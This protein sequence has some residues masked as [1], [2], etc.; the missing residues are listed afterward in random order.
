MRQPNGPSDYLKL[1]ETYKMII[2]RNIPVMDLLTKNEARRFITFI[3]A[4]YENKV[5]LIISAFA[6]PENLFI[7]QD[8]SPDTANIM[9]K[10]SLGDLLGEMFKGKQ[11][12]NEIMK[13]AIFTAEDERFAF[14]RA[15]SRL[16]EMSSSVWWN[17]DHKPQLVDSIIKKTKFVPEMDSEETLK[18]TKKGEK[19][20]QV[21]AKDAE[22]QNKPSEEQ[23]YTDG[24]DFGE[25]AAFKGY[26]K[27][28]K[29]Y[30]TLKYEPDFEK[31]QKIEEQLKLRDSS[32]EGIRE[33]QERRE[34]MA[35]KFGEFHIWGMAEW[36]ERAGRWGQGVKAYITN[37]FKRL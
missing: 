6:D 34:S 7:T 5:K 36:G 32:P 30:D 12:S 35:P 1:C 22:P 25:E 9:Q 10:E 37:I 26:L 16:K 21:S 33:W 18:S 17:E 14:M 19:T 11:R 15:V 31:V 13:L 20:D 29:R 8:I 24:S 3:D 28:F 27:Q 23:F 2:V 4:A